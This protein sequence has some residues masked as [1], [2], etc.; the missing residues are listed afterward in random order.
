[1]SRGGAHGVIRHDPVARSGG[2]RA[3]RSA[4]LVALLLLAGTP[5][6]RAAD[7][8][9]APDDRPGEPAGPG[10]VPIVEL[11]TMGQGDLMFEKFGHAAL[12]IRYARQPRRTRCYNYGTTDFDSV[13]PLIWG[14]LR[15]RSLF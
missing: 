4:S 2:D 9:G 14:F 13:V 7:P 8:E 5:S 12:C 15:G 11:Y 6:A 3:G 1:M 10:D